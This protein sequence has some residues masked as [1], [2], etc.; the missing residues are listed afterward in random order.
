[1]SVNNIQF[2]HVRCWTL[3]L[4]PTWAWYYFTIKPLLTTTFQQRNSSTKTISKQQNHIHQLQPKYS[5]KCHNTF[6]KQLFFAHFLLLILHKW[7]YWLVKPNV[8]SKFYQILA[9]QLYCS[10]AAYTIFKVLKVVVIYVWLCIRRSFM[11]TLL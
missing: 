9:A 4:K 10:A 11:M 3:T 6:L 8:Y 1:M 7:K 2:E 5:P